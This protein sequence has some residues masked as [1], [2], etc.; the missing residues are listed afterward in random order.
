MANGSAEENIQLSIENI[1]LEEDIGM[2]DELF[3]NENVEEDCVQS[4]WSPRWAV[5]KK[6]NSFNTFKL[7]T[8]LKRHLI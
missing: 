5:S 7:L 1:Y 2:V 6:S 8:K 4:L 3:R